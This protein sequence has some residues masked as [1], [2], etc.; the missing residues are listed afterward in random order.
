MIP[1]PSEMGDNDLFLTFDRLFKSLILSNDEICSTKEDDM[2][3]V[4]SIVRSYLTHLRSIYSYQRF[5]STCSSLI[6]LFILIECH[7]LKTLENNLCTQMEHLLEIFSG[8][9]IPSSNTDSFIRSILYDS[10]SII[11][12]FVTNYGLALEH[13]SKT[14]SNYLNLRFIRRRKQIIQ[15]MRLEQARK[16]DDNLVFHVSLFYISSK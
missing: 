11:S 1:N 15:V 16:Q 3:L 4:E 12:N 13:L 9:E 8:I 10:N 5:N 14:T 7:F 6:D 2:L